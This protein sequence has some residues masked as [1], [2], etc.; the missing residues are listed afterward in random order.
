MKYELLV[1]RRIGLKIWSEFVHN[2]LILPL[3]FIPPFLFSLDFLQFLAHSNIGI[4]WQLP[5]TWTLKHTDVS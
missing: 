2:G 1:M 4:K 3:Q 5:Q